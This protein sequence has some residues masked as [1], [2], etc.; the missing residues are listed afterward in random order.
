M[1]A[2]EQK[3]ESGRSRAFSPYL[4]PNEHKRL[5]E[6]IGFGDTPVPGFAD[7]LRTLARRYV[8]DGDSLKLRAICLLVAD[9]F[10]QGWQVTTKGGHIAF[11][12]PGLTRAATETIEDIKSRVRQALQAARMRQ[13]A[14]PSVRKFLERT[15]RR[16]VRPHGRRAA[17]ADLIDDGAALAVEFA[18]V[19]AL[20][21]EERDV[22]LAAIVDPVIE[23]CGAGVR[24]AD[25]GIPLIDIWRYFRHTWAHEYRSIPGR[26]MMV[27][28]RNAARPYRPIMG[29]GMLASP[30]M[31]LTARDQWIGWLR[32]SAEEHILCGD[33]CPKAFGHAIWK[34]VEASIADIRWDDLATPAEVRSPTE[35]VVMRLE[36]RAAGAAFARDVELRAHFNT[37]REEG[38]DMR[39]HRGALKTATLETD[40]RTASD[41]LTEIAQALHVPVLRNQAYFGLLVAGL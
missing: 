24:C 36:Q 37:Y 8:D 21:P 27:L 38:D 41:D 10:E 3:L 28:I 4:A 14:E 16:R 7:E 22:A 1:S 30:V 39:P 15:E 29:I 34:R 26:Q 17:I 9:L 23:V 19:N 11:A 18:R 5:Q 20:P 33:W 31:R 6:F 2:S 40:W 25:T 12:P 32:E 35:P 13:L